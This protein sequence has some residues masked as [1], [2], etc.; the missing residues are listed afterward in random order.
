MKAK[1][2]RGSGFRGAL[3][4]VFD[5]G[6]QATHLKQAELVGGNMA[7]QEP[8]DLAREFSVTRQLRPDIT[9]PVWHCSLD[10]PARR[11]LRERKME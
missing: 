10:L 5:L 11:V 6:P 1:V 4:C 7:G 2:S 8:H 9:R 3:N